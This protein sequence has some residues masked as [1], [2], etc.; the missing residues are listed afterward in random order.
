MT[1]S[2]N[3]IKF[4]RT[5]T[6]EQGGYRIY[7]IYLKGQ[8]YTFECLDCTEAPSTNSGSCVRKCFS[9][10]DNL[11]DATEEYLMYLNT[12]EEKL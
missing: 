1:D 2:S 4:F 11:K 12:W 6:D 7:T 8:T 9:E 10:F 5:P 3:V